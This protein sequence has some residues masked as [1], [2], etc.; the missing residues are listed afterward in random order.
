VIRCSRFRIELT[1]AVSR[2]GYAVSVEPI[3]YLGRPEFKEWLRLCRASFMDLERLPRR[4]R[5]VR[6]FKDEADASRFA[7]ALA[8]SLGE[9]FWM[10]LGVAAPC[11]VPPDAEGP[12]EEDLGYKSQEE[13]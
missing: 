2:V 3:L 7:A 1:E 6:W 4:W 5:M 8:Y 11:R 9:A 13:R 12:N 10:R